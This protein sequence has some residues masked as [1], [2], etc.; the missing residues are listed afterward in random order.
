MNIQSIYNIFSRW[1]WRY[2]PWGWLGF[3]FQP[4]TDVPVPHICHPC[5]NTIQIIRFIFINEVKYF[6]ICSRALSLAGPQSLAVQCPFFVLRLAMTL[7]ISGSL[8]ECV[9]VLSDLLLTCKWGLAGGCQ[10]AMRHLSF[11]YKK[12][13]QL[14]IIYWSGVYSSGEFGDRPAILVKITGK[15]RKMV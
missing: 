14:L 15:C 4:Q 8:S 5:L 2:W 9:M 3:P 7:D 10:P 12:S 11:V 6:D 13:I 1:D